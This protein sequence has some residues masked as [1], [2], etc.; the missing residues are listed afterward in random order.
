MN[1]ASQGWGRGRGEA[2]P[3]PAEALIVVEALILTCQLPAQWDPELPTLQQKQERG[4]S[5]AGILRMVQ[6]LPDISEGTT[7]GLQQLICHKEHILK[8]NLWRTHRIMTLW[9]R[10]QLSGFYSNVSPSKRPLYDYLVND[11]HPP[12]LFS[13]HYSEAIFFKKAFAFKN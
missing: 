10:A 7:K 3:N 5:T 9:L 13:F 6:A 11:K 12:Y 4:F 1:A 8:T 2:H